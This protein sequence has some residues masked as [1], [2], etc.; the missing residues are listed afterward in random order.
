MKALTLTQPWASAVALGSKRIETRS[1][2]TKY[3][4]Q[5][6]IHA[7]RAM[8]LDASFSVGCSWT[9]CGAL[10][11][12]GLRMGNGVMPHEVLPFGCII[13]VATIVDCRLTDSFTQAELDAR[14]MPDGET[15]DAYSW[16]ERMMGDFSLGRFG[17]V[18]SG[19]QLIDQPIHCKGALG[20]WNLPPL[21]E[22]MLL[23]RLAVTA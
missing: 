6:A 3:R 18:L 5:I 13:A 9:W 19:I 1:W 10:R 8:T 22:Q 12:A 17:F 4:G 20:L 15:I 16:T 23:E 14:R 2:R 21:T 11:G 7:G